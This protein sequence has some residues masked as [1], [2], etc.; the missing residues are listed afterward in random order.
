MRGVYLNKLVNAENRT[1]SLSD[2]FGIIYYVNGW[3]GSD[4]ND[5]K[6]WEK[7]FL[8]MAKAFSVITSGDTI[9]LVGR[10]TETLTAP[11]GVFDVTIIGVTAGQPR[12]STNNGVQAGYSAYWKY[13]TAS[14]TACLE[15]IEQGWKIKNIV[16]EPHSTGHAIQLT[17]AEDAVHPDPSHAIIEDCRI[18]GGANGIIDSG[19]CFGIRLINNVFQTQTGHAVKNV[20]GAGIAC[21]SY[22]QVLNNKFLGFTNGFA[23]EMVHGVFENN[24]FTD[25]GTPNTTTVLNI[26]GSGTAG[27]NNFVVNNYFQTATANFNTPDIIGNAT[28]VWNNV[29]IDGTADMIGR[30]V[31]TPA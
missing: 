27:G 7:P 6:S 20:T 9:Y 3:D 15:L 23:V 25:G 14:A 13:S 21:P 2:N 1:R 8:T 11:L 29:S 17:R 10:I 30:E 24:F 26:Y 4:S 22:W 16:F 28:D 5:G 31:G 19:G 12:Q 18:V